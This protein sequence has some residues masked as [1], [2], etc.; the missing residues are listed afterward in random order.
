MP[1]AVGGFWAGHNLSRIYSE[2][3]HALRGVAVTRADQIAF[4][5]AALRILGGSVLRLIVATIGLSAV[6]VL[7][8]PWTSGTLAI[9][10]MVAFGCLALATLLVSL[11]LSL[12]HPGRTLFA[13]SAAVVAEAVLQ[14]SHAATEPG[15][16]LIAGACVAVLLVLP[17]I[18]RLFLRPGRVLA[19]AFWIP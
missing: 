14:L 2:L 19:T 18:L 9:S 5:G 10:L 17:P 7:A 15:D 12:G 16:P 8:G 1:S 3:P 13:V 6:C 4:R 11:L